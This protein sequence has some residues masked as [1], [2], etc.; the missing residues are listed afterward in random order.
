M[1]DNALLSPTLNPLISNPPPALVNPT[2]TMEALP[3]EAR[4]GFDPKPAGGQDQAEPPLVLLALLGLGIGGAGLLAWEKW[5]WVV[6]S[7]SK[8]PARV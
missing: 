8:T 7:G 3:G 1:R 2:P 5:P 6:G 4:R